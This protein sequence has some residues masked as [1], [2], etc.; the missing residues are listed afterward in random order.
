L[1][2]RNLKSAHYS[3]RHNYQYKPHSH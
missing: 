1:M 2:K 3:G